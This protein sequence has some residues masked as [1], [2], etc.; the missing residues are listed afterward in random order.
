MS[1]ACIRSTDNFNTVGDIL[2]LAGIVLDLEL[3]TIK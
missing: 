2:M 1:K 3:T